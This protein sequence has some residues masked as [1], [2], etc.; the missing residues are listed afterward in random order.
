MRSSQQENLERF[1]LS[2]LSKEFGL[3]T[4]SSGFPV[5]PVSLRRIL[6]L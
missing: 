5:E 3:G 6:N 2:L 4:V 1:F